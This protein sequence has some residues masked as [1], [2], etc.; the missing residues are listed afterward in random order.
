M[1]F[2]DQLYKEGEK[3]DYCRDDSSSGTA[4]CRPRIAAIINAC[5]GNRGLRVI[6]SLSITPGAKSF[7]AD[8]IPHAFPGQVHAQWAEIDAPPETP[9]HFP[10]LN[11]PSTPPVRSLGPEQL[12]SKPFAI[13]SAEH[14]GRKQSFCLYRTARCDLSTK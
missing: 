3:A 13:P 9:T 12:P 5:T 8:G 6:P 11:L 4:R 7:C 14:R 1:L 2:E 10:P